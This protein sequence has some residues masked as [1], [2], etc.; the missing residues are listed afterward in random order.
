MMERSA[1]RL[2]QIVFLTASV[3]LVP[4]LPNFSVALALAPAK[5]VL[6]HRR[7]ASLSKGLPLHHPNL[8][9]WHGSAINSQNARNGETDENRSRSSKLSSNRNISWDGDDLRYWSRLQ[10]RLRR[11]IAPGG[12]GHPVR[13]M[14]I[15]SCVLVSL[16][17]ALD[18]LRYIVKQYPTHWPQ[19]A[20]YMLWDLLL[21]NASPGPFER[22]FCYHHRLAKIQ[23]HRY[24]THGLLHRGIFHLLLNMNE[25]RR[26]PGWLETGLGG[27]LYLTTFLVSTVAGGL[28]HSAWASTGSEPILLGAS[29]GICGLYGLMWVSL[30]KMGKAGPSYRALF[31]MGVVVLYS[32]L[33]NGVSNAAH[34]GGFISGTFCGLLFGPSYSVSYAMRRKWSTYVDQEP[35]DYRDAMGFGTKSSKGGLLPLSILWVVVA[36]MI[37]FLPAYRS[38]PTTVFR[39]ITQPGSLSY[40]V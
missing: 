5:L 25:L 13:S 14:I 37:A 29:P 21:A 26:Q 7:P 22:D 31:G 35:K 19:S 16:Y 1:F 30:A 6:N 9:L 4:C 23:P 36:A 20:P 28:G 15:I 3:Y 10:R 34:L 2:V 12:G 38:I 27:P 39:A 40:A 11:S 24:I 32:F 17:Q 8:G 18:T 33:L